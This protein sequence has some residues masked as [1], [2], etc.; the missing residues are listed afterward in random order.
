MDVPEATVQMKPSPLTTVELQKCGSRLLHLTPKK[1]LDI[2]E[3]LYQ[4]DATERAEERQSPSSHPP[5]PT[6]HQPEWG[7]EA[8]VRVHHPAISGM[9][10]KE[11][12]GHLE[13]YVYKKWGGMLLLD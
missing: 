8:G 6:F 11:C 1:V 12:S 9:L 4:K 5:N 10:L 13:V 7:Q 2:A 3:K